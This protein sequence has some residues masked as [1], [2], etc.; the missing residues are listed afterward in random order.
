M[1]LAEQLE[2]IEAQRNSLESEKE[3]T[4]QKHKEEVEKLQSS[5]AAVRQ[6]GEQ[7]QDVL[8]E[9]R[10][11]KEQLGAQLQENIHMVLKLLI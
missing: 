9:L 5:L 7:L 6:E 1:D 3:I 10:E 11:E 8:L 2:I 4:L